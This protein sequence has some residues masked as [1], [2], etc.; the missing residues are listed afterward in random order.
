MWKPLKQGLLKIKLVG[1][2]LTAIRSQRLGDLLVRALS[3]FKKSPWI[4][5]S[6]ILTA[7]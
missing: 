5:L 6:S 2:R 4:P 7:Q 3:V 1:G